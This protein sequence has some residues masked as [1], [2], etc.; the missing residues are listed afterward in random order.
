MLAIVE[1]K[2]ED[3]E[4]DVEA[5]DEDEVDEVPGSAN[6]VPNVGTKVDEEQQFPS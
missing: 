1:D 4:E 2:D 6:M 5:A 3:E